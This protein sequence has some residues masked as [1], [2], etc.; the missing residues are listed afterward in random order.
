[1]ESAS[2][3]G[4]LRWILIPGFLVAIWVASA[5]GTAEATTGSWTTVAPMPTGRLALA[6]T[7]GSDG[8]IYAIGGEGGGTKDVVESYQPTSNTWTSVSSLPT[9]RYALAAA[10]GT[11]GTIYAIGGNDAVDGYTNKMTAY[12]PSSDTWTSLAPMPTRRG[13]LAATTG[14]DGRIYAIGGFDP[15]L[16]S[17]TSAVE[18]YDPLTDSWTALAPMPTPRYSLGA[19][20]GA[21]GRIYAIG[22]YAGSPTNVVE[23]YDPTTNTWTAAAPMPTARQQLAVA[24]SDGLVYA[25]G[26]DGLG[27]VTTKAV[28]AYNP[29]T[30][31]W[32]SDTPM[33]TPTVGLAAASALDGTIFTMGGCT[34]SSGCGVDTVMAFDPSAVSAVRPDPPTNVSAVAGNQKATVTWSAPASDGG[35]PITSYTVT[36]SPGGQTATVNGSTITAVVS[37]LTNCATYTFTVRATNAIG[38][39]D[40][41]A[42]SDGVTPSTTT[43][44]SVSDSGNQVIYSPKAIDVPAEQC[45]RVKWTFGSASTPPKSHT[46]TEASASSQGLGPNG[47]PLFNS[48]LVAPGGTFTYLFKGATAYQYRSIA[49]GDSNSPSLYGIVRMPV[50]VSPT[51]GSTTTAFTVRWAKAAIPGYSFTIEYQLKLTSAKTWPTTWTAWFKDQTGTTATFIPPPKNKPGMY[52]FRARIK[53]VATGKMGGFS[54][55][56]ASGLTCPCQI[57][58][59]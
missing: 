31:T 13:Y 34:P 43:D 41:S 38:T 47:S 46:V 32:A 9:P 4:R 44:V 23:A 10:T 37:G 50:I 40:P 6:A 27:F 36:A 52:R 2:P 26:G 51:S 48:G 28:E 58:V 8:T 24:S 56:D 17:Q 45:A 55:T 29:T 7:T 14:P 1:M 22:G 18:A 49:A 59:T 12:D 25:I 11:D 19:A 33:P 21:D 15:A 20:T 42:A 53:N 3:R 35:S 30:N 16:G 5:F 57:T 54:W 39:S